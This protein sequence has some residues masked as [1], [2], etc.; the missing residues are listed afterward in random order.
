MPYLLYTKLFIPPPPP[1]QKKKKKAQRWKV[2]FRALVI[3]ASHPQ[4]PLAWIP[5]TP[6]PSIS[7]TFLHL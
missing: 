2:N 6:P 1:P 3:W 4:N 5:P 7:L